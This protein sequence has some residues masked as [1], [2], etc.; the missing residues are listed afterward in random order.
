MGGG[1]KS[2][3]VGYRIYLG[4][5]QVLCSGPIDKLTRI[6]F[7]NKLAWLGDQDGTVDGGLCIISKPD[8]FGGDSREGGVEGAVKLNSGGSAQLPDSYLGAQLG[9]LV[10]AFRG[11]AA[12][13]FQ[14]VY[15][16]MNP[17]LKR[18]KYR[19]QRIFVT[20]T[21][22][23]Q[24]YAEKAAI[25]TSGAA[26]TT[27]DI[28]AVTNAIHKNKD[29]MDVAVT[30][31]GFRTSDTIVVT[32][33]HAGAYVAFSP[34][35]IP[36]P[37]AHHSGA[38]YK[39]SV[40]K[41]G[42]GSAAT[43][44]GIDEIDEMGAADGYAA[45]RALFESTYPNGIALTGASSYSFFIKDSN[46][47]DNTGG[48]SLTLTTSSS[49][50]DMNPAHIIREC[51][52]DV[53]WGMGYS[54]GD[55]DDDSFT[56]AAD[57]LFGEGFGLSFLWDKQMQVEDFIKEVLKHI[58]GS[59]FIDRVTGL[60]TL[61]LIRAD[62]NVDDLLV[63]DE[64]SIDKVENFDQPKMGELVTSV[65][66][67]FW[68]A[69]TSKPGTVIVQDIA[70]ETMQNAAINL[71]VHYSG[72]TKTALANRLAQRNLRTLSFGP[73]TCTIYANRLASPLKM[74]SAFIMRWN[75][76][77]IGEAVMRVV[78]IVYGDGKNNQIRILC[79]Q[80]T[81]SFPE[82]SISEPAPPI[83]TDPI[84][85]PSPVD[86]QIAFE[87]PYYELVTRMGQASIDNL[88]TTDPDIGFIGV[89]AGN[90]SS[91]V[92]A[93]LFVDD[94]SGYSDNS[95]LDF[96]PTAT[97]N[98]IVSISE[99]P[100]TAAITMTADD[101]SNV[102][103]GSWAYLDD[104]AI[105]VTAISTT[106]I[107]FNRGVLD[108]VPSAHAAGSIIYFTDNFT[109]S[110]EIQ[111][112][113]GES[114]LIKLC[115]VMGSSQSALDDADPLTLV[116]NQRAMRPYPPGNVKLDSLYYP[117]RVD[118]LTVALTWAH[119][120]RTQQTSTT[121]LDFTDVSVGPEVGTT[122]DLELLAEDGLTI[123]DAATAVSGTSSSLTGTT[124][125]PHFIRITAVRD[126]LDS[127]FSHLIPVILAVEGHITEENNARVTEDGIDT[128]VN[129]D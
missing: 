64:H 7:D 10:P 82:A 89:A 85:D 112:A 95:A 2:V 88:L 90:P 73:F 65:T 35:G 123:E 11:V 5:H 21:G 50:L 46:I 87:M 19:A 93:R 55:I 121:L 110:D 28:N 67:Q 18:I 17:Y 31:S 20:G 103:L 40:A 32:P 56:E 23:E 63:L 39:F 62:Y 124:E 52:T 101:V 97:L 125:G 37:I 107:S 54:S 114:L 118:S 81:F 53:D 92:S 84:E 59:L 22:A 116:M 75:E 78:G 128:R 105:V 58:D 61:K 120:D 60:F 41:D 99:G 100:V 9:E 43:Q 44:Y 29:S 126:G 42:N 48:I 113:S 69:L 80:D 77:S 24:W 47:P 51:I 1:S 91:G 127:L 70:L 68:E 3:T 115:T 33:N 71:T 26:S 83:W 129:E 30:V 122:Y 111:Y 13:V 25:L 15:M 72:V 117:D 79:T 4:L 8:L 119:R 76:F 86:D 38:I 106:S 104:E 66:V 57:T 6:S 94:G 45:A 16:G 109:A 98:Q 14:H 96:A 34:W 102:T 12:V 27:V 74:G 49:E 108:T 36:S